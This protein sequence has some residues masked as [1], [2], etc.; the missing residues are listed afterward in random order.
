MVG[1]PDLDWLFRSAEE[2]DLSASSASRTFHTERV[3]FENQVATS[4]GWVWHPNEK[5]QAPAKTAGCQSR[6]VPAAGW[7]RWPRG[8]PAVIDG[9]ARTRR[10]RLHRLNCSSLDNPCQSPPAGARSSLPSNWA[11]RRFTFVVCRILNS[12]SLVATPACP[13]PNGPY[14][15][16]PFLPVADQLP[17][18]EADGRPD[19]DVHQRDEEADFPPA[20]ERHVVVREEHR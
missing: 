10:F 18:G 19:G 7:P 9:G 17:P 13:V 20:P 11:M 8:R 14:Q 15:A 2:N 1:T 4:G 16:D 12:V 3:R 6:T 5:A